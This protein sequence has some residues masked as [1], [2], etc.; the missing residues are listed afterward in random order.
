MASVKDYTF[1]GYGVVSSGS[2]VKMFMGTDQQFFLGGKNAMTIGTAN[3]F[4][5][6]IKTDVMVGPAVSMGIAFSGW[7]ATKGVGFQSG[8]LTAKYDFSTNKSFA[9]QIAE[10]GSSNYVTQSKFIC[11]KGFQAV[12]GFQPTGQLIYSAYK[13][14][15]SSMGKVVAVTNF[16]MAIQ[17]IAQTLES[18]EL[19][20]EETLT[21]ARALWAQILPG[22]VA[23]TS[24]GVIT[25]A[26]IY[27]A[28]QR[29]TNFKTLIHPQSVI[30]LTKTSVFLGALGNGWDPTQQDGAS[31]TLAK[32][33]ATLG[34]RTIGLDE[35]AEPYTEKFNEFK[36]K[37][38]SALAIDSK[39]VI[40]YASASISIAAGSAIGSD[41][42]AQTVKKART[43]FDASVDT[44][45]KLADAAFDLAMKPIIVGYE[46]AQRQVA[47][48]AR[49]NSLLGSKPAIIAAHTAY[50]AALKYHEINP[51][52]FLSAGSKSKSLLSKIEATAPNF[53]VI[54]PNISLATNSPKTPATRGL[55]VT[56]LPTTS[57]ELVQSP[58]S[59]ISIDTTGS[60]A[61]N[62][63]PTTSMNLKPTGIAIKLGAN[64]IS[65]NPMG[66]TIKAGGTKIELSFGSVRVGNSLKVMG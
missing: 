30:D 25:G 31:L 54:A 44:A 39:T 46:E 53:N 33:K 56:T 28:I 41:P 18:P 23:G 50:Q 26:A 21:G 20:K 24:A 2:S 34:A 13:S 36:S 19:K 37:P 35:S 17:Q 16:L 57:I 6:G 10:E 49:E 3:T 52:L 48:K 60:I 51:S 11:E 40:S 59:K 62:V 58:V 1:T 42:M 63:N 9:F 29:E 27:A 7:D 43:A 12:G 45:A 4:T 14:T 65:M 64:S 32:G 55:F 22:V 66:A 38:T 61:L 8:H 5:A 15:I 47:L